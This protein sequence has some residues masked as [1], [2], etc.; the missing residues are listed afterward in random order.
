MAQYGS[1]IWPNII[2]AVQII[3]GV[4]MGLLVI[5]RFIKESVQMYRATKRFQL[6]QYMNLL[7]REGMIYFLA[8]VYLSSMPLN[9]QQNIMHSFLTAALI[10]PRYSIVNI[11]QDGWWL[12]LGIAENTPPFTLVSRFILSLRKL[13]AR[14]LRGRRGS[15][16]DTAFGFTSGYGAAASGIMFA[17]SGQSDGLEHGEEIQMEEREIHGAGSG[18]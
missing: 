6:N 1:P 7:V 17:D 2:D 3:L 15:N 8:Y 13:Y 10:N 9:S 14:N 18:A 11:P 16:I 5:I 12:L 4:F